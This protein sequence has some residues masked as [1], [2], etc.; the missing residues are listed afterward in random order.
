MIKMENSNLKELA[1]FSAPCKSNYFN[2]GPFTFGTSHKDGDVVNLLIN[3]DRIGIGLV[4]TPIWNKM[5]RSYLSSKLYFCDRIGFSK[6]VYHNK[7]TQ[8]KT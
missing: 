8:E 5:H 6:F 1:C 2:L 7:F 4:S 3:K